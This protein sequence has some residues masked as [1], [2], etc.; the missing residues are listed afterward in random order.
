[1]RFERVKGGDKFAFKELI[2]KLLSGDS[3]KPLG[4]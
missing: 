4:S 3:D 2:Q 1:M